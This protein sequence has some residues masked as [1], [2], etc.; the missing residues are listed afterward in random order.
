MS[1]KTPDN[2]PCPVCGATDFEW[3]KLQASGLDFIPVGSGI[4][5]KVLAGGFRLKAR[6]CKV[7]Q[8]LQLFARE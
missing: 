1:E 4:M 5:R 6:K 3:G 7:C 8:N 2:T